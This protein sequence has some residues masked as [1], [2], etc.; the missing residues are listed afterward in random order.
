MGRTA[1]SW[2]S[3][4][5]HTDTV[6]V[7]V[8][9]GADKNIDANVSVSVWERE[10][11]KQRKEEY[12]ERKKAHT[13]ITLTALHVCW[14]GALAIS[15]ADF[16]L[17]PRSIFDKGAPSYFLLRFMLSRAPTFSL[18]F[19]P[20]Q[21]C[22]RPTRLVYISLPSFIVW[23][24]CLFKMAYFPLVCVEWLHSAHFCFDEGSHR[25]CKAPGGGWSCHEGWRWCKRKISRVTATHK[26]THACGPKHFVA[27]AVRRCMSNRFFFSIMICFSRGA[28]KRDNSTKDYNFDV[29]IS[30]SSC[31]RFGCTWFKIVEWTDS[32]LAV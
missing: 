27:C 18:Y 6:Q 26:D 12:E 21:T 31:V 7:L 10:R 22:S 1:L 13:L 11:G 9:S 5:G 14:G 2:A 8:E 20:W 29:V 4:N 24:L 23:S 16:S 32:F 28:G 3:L 17:N 15:L 30:A 19:T 25:C